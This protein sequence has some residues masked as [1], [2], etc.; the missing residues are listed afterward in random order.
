MTC[1]CIYLSV[2]LCRYEDTGHSAPRYSAYVRQCPPAVLFC[3][4]YI[5]H[6]WCAALGWSSKEQVFPG[7]QLDVV[8]KSFVLSLLSFLL[9]SRLQTIRSV[10]KRQS[11]LAI[12]NGISSA[13]SRVNWTSHPGVKSALGSGPLSSKEAPLSKMHLKVHISKCTSSLSRFWYNGTN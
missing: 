5:W 7:Q 12:N 4:L 13:E 9:C 3:V 2:S 11:N 8:S 6:C 1:E 10:P